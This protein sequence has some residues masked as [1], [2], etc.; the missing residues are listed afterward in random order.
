[1]LKHHSSK[2]EYLPIS[3][4]KPRMALRSIVCSHS[5]D[6][7]P[8]FG[9]QSA[10]I[11]FEDY[12]RQ[13]DGVQAAVDPIYALSPIFRF[14]LSSEMSLLD[15]VDSNI[16]GELTH[17]VVTAQESPT[18]SNLLY[19]QQILKRHLDSLKEAI[20]F[21]EGFRKRKAYQ[22]IMD[23]TNSK[24]AEDVT[25]MLN[26]FHAAFDRAKSLCDECIQGIG[27]VAHNAT[28]QESQ[29]AFA[30][31]RS[32]TKLTK[33]ALVFV[34]LS[35]TTSAFGMNV[36]ELGNGDAP[37][38]WVWLIITV[39]I[40][41]PILVFFKWNASELQTFAQVILTGICLHTSRWFPGGERF[42]QMT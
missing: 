34:P 4:F 12:D 26:D 20:E 33:L 27:I 24:Y 10:S 18:M 19:N 6:T 14:A 16:R 3:I 17:S 31:A 29:K 22:S 38:L 35:F 36:R 2:I 40:G 1:M 21:V 41:L 32:V 23:N 37:S 25:S 11:L 5:E 30:E 9:L 13:L 42:N 39:S 8:L 7:R 15:T 28:I